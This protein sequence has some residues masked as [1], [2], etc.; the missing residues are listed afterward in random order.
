MT[1]AETVD[2]DLTG[3]D[4]IAFSNFMLWRGG[5]PGSPLARGPLFWT[6]LAVFLVA[7]IAFLVSNFQQANLG[8]A[9]LGV[10][11]VGV[12][13]FFLWFGLRQR[14]NQVNWHGKILKRDDPLWQ[15]VSH[16]T[17]S[18]TAEGVAVKMMQKQPPMQSESLNQ[19]TGI[20]AI[21]VTDTHIFL[22]QSD[23]TCIIVPRRVFRSEA[24]AQHFIN[25][26]QEYRAVERP[27]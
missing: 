15:G 1:T 26:A 12:I 23:T 11:P 13:A 22:D 25:T 20:R 18:L 6:L 9:L 16:M 2:F 17:V 21:Q 24:E 27:L 10:A 7:A 4:L 19:W 14:K 8:T 5:V 3:D